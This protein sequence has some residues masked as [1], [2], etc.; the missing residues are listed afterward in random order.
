MKG[1]LKGLESRLPEFQSVPFWSWNDKLDKD[2]LTRQIQWMKQQGIGGFFMHARGGLRTEYMSE[3]WMQCVDA[4]IKA[5]EEQGMQAWIYD[6]NGWPSGF[7]GGKLLQKEE[8]LDAHITYKIG[9]YDADAWLT[10]SLEKE[11]A[12]PCHGADA[13]SV[14]EFVPEHFPLYGRYFKSG[15]D[16]SVFGGNSR[17]I[18]TA[19]WG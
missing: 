4:C 12:A 7:A 2:I 18:R 6:E 19:L 10:Y 8:N 14:P 3:E 17:K 9:A 16:R 5:A 11:K 15:S 13:G 1:L